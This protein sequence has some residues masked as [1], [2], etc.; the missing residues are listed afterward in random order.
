M[1]TLPIAVVVDVDPD[2]RNAE[3]NG[4]PSVG[5]MRWE[6]LR[7]GVPRLLHLLSDIRD[8]DGRNVRF[9]WMLR[10]DEQ[11]ANAYDDPA[12]LADEF[13]PFWEARLRA[14]DEIG[15]HPHA[16]RFSERDKIWYQERSDPDWIRIC[17]KEGFSALSR[18]FP[19]RVAKT[20]WTYHNNLSMQ[21][22]SE[23]G[24]RFDLSALPGMVYRGSIPGTDYPMGEYDWGRTPQEPYHPRPDDYQVPG[25]SHA[26]PILEIPN[27]TYPVGGFRRLDHR[28]RGRSWRDFANPA[29]RPSLV[30][31]GFQ[32]PPY[33]VPFVCYFHPEELLSPSW[34]FAANHVA[35][36]LIDLLD[37]C[38]AR[39][40][41]P[42]FASGSELSVGA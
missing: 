24:V 34:L 9:T 6:G 20:G 37:A 38:K 36:N 17:L 31:R 10:A 3:T 18:R 16:W 41:R 35:Q 30:G 1:P 5:D 2:W 26:L 22:F 21:I 15:W 14:G 40:I 13:A 32:H 28:L 7:Q 29:K 39:G 12:Y 23:L 11:M 8:P 42:R 19:I 33:S 4:R 25:D 27:W